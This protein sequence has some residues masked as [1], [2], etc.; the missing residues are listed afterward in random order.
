MYNIFKMQDNKPKSSQSYDLDIDFLYSDGEQIPSQKQSLQQDT[1]DGGS[2]SIGTDE[3]ISLL[4]KKISGVT[5]NVDDTT[6]M[7]SNA[8]NT[9]SDADTTESDYLTSINFI[10]AEEA[11][12]MN[13][14]VPKQSGGGDSDLDTIMKVAKEYFKQ[15]GG[16]SDV[17]DSDE[18][19]DD[20]DEVSG[21]DDSSVKKSSSEKKPAPKPVK[22]AKASKPKR[23]STPKRSQK[24]Q[25][26]LNALSE[27]IDDE[28]PAYREGSVES[29]GSSDT[30]YIEDSASINT[31]SINLVS[32]ENPA[33]TSNLKKAKKPKK[34]GKASKK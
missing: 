12:K 16:G 27:S 7:N 24:T 14:S 23:A 11:K 22:R 10:S 4:K 25:R 20:S 6:F 32:F 13:K 30:A 3:F 15:N 28:K 2:E 26:G 31:S 19:L 34:G 9:E 5:N 18:D 21:S 29:F 33:L 17:S 8:G 1:H